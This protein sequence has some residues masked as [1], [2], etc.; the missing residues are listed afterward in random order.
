M[1]ERLEV[2]EVQMDFLV[3]FA[4]IE[5]GM[6]SIGDKGHYLGSSLCLL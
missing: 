5:V 3:Y 6:S 4:V 2:F 1:V